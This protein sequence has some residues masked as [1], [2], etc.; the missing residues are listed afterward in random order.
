VRDW[1]ILLLLISLAVALAIALWAAATRVRRHNMARQKVAAEGERGA[2]ALLESSGYRVLDRQVT[3]RWT[4]WVDGQ[5][6]SVACRA[7][8]LV[9][10]AAG[11]R[12]VAE[13][14]TGHLAPDPLRPSTRRQ[15]LEYWLAFQVDGVLLVDMAERR[16]SGLSF[17]ARRR[18]RGSSGARPP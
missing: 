9:A 8:L 16:I 2:A 5:P 18:Y 10:D 17:D 4:V 14:K 11:G 7:D 12:F 13:V 6:C 3:T 15:L 1:P